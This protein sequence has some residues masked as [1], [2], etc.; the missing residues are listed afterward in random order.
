MRL[1]Q[2]RALLLAA[3]GLGTL[4]AA[5]AG[6]QEIPVDRW[7]VTSR[8]VE[9]GSDPLASASDSLPASVDGRFPDRNLE[10][11]AGV[12]TLVRRDGERR[13]DFAEWTR[14]GETTL[15]HAYLKAPADTDVRLALGVEACV[16]LRAWLNGQPLAEPEQPREVRLAGGWNTFLVVLDGEAECERAISA[17]LSPETGP[18]HRRGERPA[19]VVVQASRPPGVRPNHPHG[20]V[21]VSI[22]RV[23]ALTWHP[24]GED[25]VAAVRY[26]LASWGGDAVDPGT[27]VEAPGVQRR[28]RPPIGPFGLRPFGGGNRPG[29]SDDDGTG[30]TDPDGQRAGMVAQL[31]GRPEPKP[32]AP[33]DGSVELRLADESLVAAGSDLRPGRPVSFDGS[34]PFRKLREAA[35]REDG[36]KTEFRWSGGGDAEGEGRLPAAPVLRALHGTLDL[37]LEA[38]PGGAWRGRLRVPDALAGFA[39]QSLAG[40]WTVDGTAAADR[41]LCDPCERGRWIEVEFRGAAEDERPRARIV[42]PVLPDLTGGTGVSAFELLRA[43]EGDNRRYRELLGG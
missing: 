25:L 27:D 20:V 14:P 3:W 16:G 21:T 15:A 31:L 13:F 32:P 43:L 23:T 41:I 11:E 1:W 7:L 37:G 42:D 22:P 24:D 30:P 29:A 10:T 9:A 5:A 38:V 4:G 34:V 2:I 26:D 19:G 33:R 36:M 8:Q 18:N 6:A 39:V 12:W 35:L 17:T 40:S 28:G